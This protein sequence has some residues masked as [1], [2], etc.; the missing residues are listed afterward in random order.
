MKD[1]GFLFEKLEV[2]RRSL[3]LA[4]RFLQLASKFP[5]QLS[6]IRDQL[7]GAALSTPLNIAEGSGRV[8]HKDKKNFYKNSRGSLFELIPIL[9]AVRHLHIITETERDDFRSEIA[10]LARMLSGLMRSEKVA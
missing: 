2:Y 7:I 5:P 4:M 6:R 10:H 8:S 9:E 1:E 3:A